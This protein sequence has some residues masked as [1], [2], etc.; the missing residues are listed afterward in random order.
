MSASRLTIAFTGQRLLNAEFLA[1]LQVEGVPF[2]F[3]DD[4]LLNNLSLE[5]AERVLNRLAV[6]EPHLSQL[7]PPSRAN[8]SGAIMGPLPASEG[9]RAAPA[10]PSVPCWA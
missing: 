10:F 8:S 4:V 3:P 1:R 2:N 5:A 7:P 6:L 9:S